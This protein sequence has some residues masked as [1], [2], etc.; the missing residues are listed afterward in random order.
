MVSTKGIK[1]PTQTPTPKTTVTGDLTPAA[2]GSDTLIGPNAPAQT[3]T[4]ATPLI[5]PLET[6]SLAVR[7]GQRRLKQIAQ[8]TRRA[9]D[10]LP[11]SLVKTTGTGPPKAPVV[12]GQFQMG[13]ATTQTPVAVD[14]R[15][16]DVRCV[17]AVRLVQ[18]TQITATEKV[19]RRP[20][21]L[22]VTN[23]PVRRMP[24]AK[25]MVATVVA[26]P[27]RVAPKDVAMTEAPSEVLTIPSTRPAIADRALLLNGADR[28]FSKTHTSKIL[29]F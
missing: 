15:P 12:V 14:I 28:P 24:M 3:G 19:A 29:V 2:G 7:L 20:T 27:R 25:W 17:V 11:T 6:T 8:V 10:E 18:V 26:R 9:T 5:G 1:R 23:I 16:P 13:T 21:A 22:P 4:P